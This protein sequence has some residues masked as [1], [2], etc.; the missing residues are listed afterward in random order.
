MVNIHFK[1]DE[2]K[3]EGLLTIDGD[4]TIQHA[5]E[6]KN[7]LLSAISEYDSIKIYLDKVKEFDLACLQLLVAAHK[8]ALKRN[9]TLKIFGNQAGML[10][11]AIKTAGYLHL[12]KFKNL[13]D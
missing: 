10:E 8:T 13:N 12:I 3:Q 6:Y 2:S 11:R 7:A 5:T 4:L 1:T 9:K